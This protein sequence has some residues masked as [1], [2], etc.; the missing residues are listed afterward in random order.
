MH[1]QR[2]SFAFSVWDCQWINLSA[3]LSQVRHPNTVKHT[4]LI[5]TGYFSGWWISQKGT[6]R[7][8]N[9]LQNMPFSTIRHTFSQNVLKT[10]GLVCPAHNTTHRYYGCNIIVVSN[11]LDLRSYENEQIMSLNWWRTMLK[12]TLYDEKQQKN[13]P[14]SKAHHSSKKQPQSDLPIRGASRPSLATAAA[15]PTCAHG[16]WRINTAHPFRANHFHFLHHVYD[17]MESLLSTT[18]TT[19]FYVRLMREHGVRKKK[20]SHK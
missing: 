16:M 9:Q 10:R 20:Y 13:A 11:G 6:L 4:L 14:L 5:R 1:C 12:E 18:V 8:A 15:S 17:T 7:D 2:F 3:R 19:N